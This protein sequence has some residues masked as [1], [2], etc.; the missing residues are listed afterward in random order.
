MIPSSTSTSLGLKSLSGSTCLQH[1]AL[2]SSEALSRA[3]LFGGRQAGT[4]EGKRGV[5]PKLQSSHKAEDRWFG[6]QRRGER[7]SSGGWTS[8]RRRFASAPSDLL[9]LLWAAASAASACCALL[10]S[11][12]Q[13]T[14]GSL[15]MTFFDDHTAW[16]VAGADA[17]P[18]ACPCL[19]GGAFCTSCSRTGSILCVV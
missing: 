9:C 15:H 13:N 16:S 17:V 2:A 8:A 3:Q 5:K 6:R 19:L 7:G 1:L 18:L 12:S 14:H 10:C 4:A 11:Q